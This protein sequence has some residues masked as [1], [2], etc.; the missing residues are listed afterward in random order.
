[1]TPAHPIDR[2]NGPKPSLHKQ[3]RELVG[4]KKFIT[5]LVSPLPTG[6]GT[7]AAFPPPSCRPDL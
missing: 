1:M 7:P 2:P 3:I 6:A 4:L 5:A